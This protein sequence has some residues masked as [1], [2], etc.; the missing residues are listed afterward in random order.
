MSLQTKTHPWWAVVMLALGVGA[1]S[2]LWWLI[3]IGLA[4]LFGRKVP[5]EICLK[6]LNKLKTLAV[7][8]LFGLVLIGVAPLVPGFK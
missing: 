8:V 7:V 3:F 1:G 2:F 4:A 5:E 6:S